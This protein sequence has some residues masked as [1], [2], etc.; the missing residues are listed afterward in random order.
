MTG[1]GSG[2]R[3]GT[4]GDAAPFTRLC[5]MIENVM[6]AQVAGTAARLGLADRLSAGPL[7]GDELARAIGAHPDVGQRFLRACAAIGLIA[8]DEPGTFALT[9]LGQLLRSDRHEFGHL[10]ITLTS[11]GFWLPVGRLPDVVRTGICGA[12]LAF[13]TPVWEY[14]RANPEEGA[15]FAAA[16][17]ENTAQA[18]AGMVARY[19]FSR[20][21]RIVD[22]GGS[23]GDLLAAILAAAP[24]ATGVLFDQ[25]ETVAQAPD[26]IAA[27]GVADRVEIVG[28]NFLED[29][30][31]GGDLYVA[32]LVLCDWADEDAVKI[33]R[34]CRR[35][36][37]PGSRLLIADELL[38]ADAPAVLY[39]QDLMDLAVCGGRLR[40]VADMEK[41]VAD[42]GYHPGRVIATLDTMTLFG[43]QAP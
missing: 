1:S 23:R 30:P 17:S 2:Q 12:E 24:A 35:A 15:H 18:A 29:V 28:G 10:A 27:A 19:D 22:V 33:L 26:V 9:P 3:D 34:N 14:Y 16:M 31:S 43:A 38:T 21:E 6:S 4:G 32:K 37:R 13:G 8:E 11:P 36:G 7:P 39:M 20:F 40:T 41:L 25:P 42:A 5:G